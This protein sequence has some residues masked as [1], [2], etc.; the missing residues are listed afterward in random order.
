MGKARSDVYKSA[1]R[2]YTVVEKIGE[3]GSGTV[4]C[5]TDPDSNRYAL[6]VLDSSKATSQKLKRFQNEIRFCQQ[7]T[8]ENV[9]R[10]LDTGSSADGRS[11]YVMELYPCTLQETLGKLAPGEVPQA[12]SQVLNGVEVAHLKSVSHRDLKPQN[13]LCDPKKKLYVI[14]DFGIAG[15]G[16]EEL[17]TVVETGRNERLANFQ[18]AAPE[19][20]ARGR[21]VGPKADVYALGLMLNQMFTGEIPLGTQFKKIGTVATEFSYLDEVVEQMIRQDPVQRPSIADVKMQLIAR[22]QQFVSLQKLDA[23]SKQVVP[24]NSV[25][26]PLVTDPIRPQGFDYNDGHLLITLS[27]LPNRLWIDKFQ[28]QATTQFV[29]MGPETVTFQGQVAWVPTRKSIVAQQ[30]SYFEGWIR[31]ANGLYEEEI[32]RRMQDEMRRLQEELQQ[33]AAK[34][35]E[36]QEILKLLNPP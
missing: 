32:K 17:Y 29:G 4:Y 36:R 1:F 6:K 14:A 21:E 34:E 12:F 5:V 28:T 3:G 23:L 19:Q 24:Q 7:T 10:V 20:R 11:F 31:N 15:F 26:D 13:I 22:H 35:R 2:T 16:E 33:Q 18:Y 30:K 8:H 25:T 27:R 9:I